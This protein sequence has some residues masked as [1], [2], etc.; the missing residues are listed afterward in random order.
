MIYVDR[1]DVDTPKVLVRAHAQKLYREA[2]RYFKV[3][4]KKR[5]QTR[6]QFTPVYND[7]SVRDALNT[8]FQGKCAYCESQLGPSGEFAVDH[9]RPETGAVGLRRDYSPDH[10]WWLA[11]AWFNLYAV[12]GF[13]N[14]FKGTMFPVKGRRAPPEASLQELQTEERLLLDPCA[15]KPLLH[16]RFSSSGTV[17]GVTPLGRRTIAV[18][19]LNRRDLVYGFFGDHNG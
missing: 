7:A 1:A 9:F 10:Y 6:F 5:R 17:T 3:P 2:R 15:D 12:C 4:E 11:Y 14:S 18:L 8:L 19:A 16:L 13:C